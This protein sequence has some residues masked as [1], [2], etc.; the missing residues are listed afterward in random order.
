MLT[1]DKM[2][3][4]ENI[5]NSCRLFQQEWKIIKIG[6]GSQDVDIFK[7]YCDAKDHIQSK[8]KYGVLIEGSAIGNAINSIYFQ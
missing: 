3:T 2:E 7:G 6:E 8:A 5:A 1:G 4:A